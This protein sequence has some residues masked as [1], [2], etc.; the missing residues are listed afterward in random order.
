[1]K[2]FFKSLPSRFKET[3]AEWQSDHAMHLAAAFACYSI[4]FLSPLLLAA[5]SIAGLVW[6]PRPK[7]GEAS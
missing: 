1:M 7:P 4:F 6:G 5:I 3:A 2:Q